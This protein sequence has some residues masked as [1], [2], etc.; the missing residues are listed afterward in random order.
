MTRNLLFL[1]LAFLCAS[2][3][4]GQTLFNGKDLEGWKL[5][6][7]SVGHWTVIDEVIDCD[8]RSEAPTTNDSLF[9][10]QMSS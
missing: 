8:A 2:G 3:A 4:S 1:S 5:H 6:P 10:S 7:G 9:A